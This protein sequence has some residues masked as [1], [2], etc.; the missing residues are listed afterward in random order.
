MPRGVKKQ[1]KKYGYNVNRRKQWKKARKMPTV[2]CEQLKNAWDQHKSV[3]Q[4]LMDMGVASDPNKV[5]RIPKVH[6]V[7]APQPIEKMD[8]DKPDKSKPLKPHVI[9]EMM[10][11]ASLPYAKRMKLSDP[12]VKYCIHLMDKYGEDYK[13]MARDKKNYYQDTPKQ[14]KKKIAL[15][16]QMPEQYKK[17]LEDKKQREEQSQM[18]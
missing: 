3:H 18:S 13:A 15:F 8:V 14:I 17:Y 1:N 4:N 6:E 16:K 12:M 5:L 11:E 10:Q 7:M 2:K 9:D